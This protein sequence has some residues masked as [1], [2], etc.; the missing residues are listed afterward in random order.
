MIRHTAA[1]PCPVCGGFEAMPRGQGKRCAGFTS[2]DRAWV[3]CER[4]EHAGSL[5]LDERTTPATYLHRIGG[6]CNCGEEHAPAQPAQNGRRHPAPSERR[7]I[8]A[9]YLYTD[10][11]GCRVPYR[12]ARFEP[13]GFLPQHVTEA[14]AWANGFASEERVPY[15]LS[16]LIAEPDRVVFWCEGER[17][18]ETL[19]AAGLLATT[20]AGG[21]KS[22]RKHA[23][24]YAEHFRGRRLVAVLPDNDDDGRVYAAEV[25][26][27]LVAVGTE[28][29]LVELPGLPAKGDVSDWLDAC[30]TVEELRELVKYASRWAP[31][32]AA[33]PSEPHAIIRSSLCV[34]EIANSHRAVLLPAETGVARNGAAL[35]SDVESFLARFVVYPSE[36][37]RVAHV[38]WI[39]H[40]HNMEVWES[41]PRI[42]FLSPEPGSGKT[43]ALEVT[44]LLVPRPVLAVNCTSAFLFRRVADP[45]GLPTILFDEID[46]VFG[47][48]AKSENED[49]RGLLN[50]GHRKGAVAGRCVVKGKRIETEELP[51]YA[52]VALAGLDDLPATLESR[53]VV[54]RMRRR[55]PDELVQPF[56]RRECESQAS[57]IREALAA[58]AQTIPAGE[59][60]D[61]PAG[62]AD[63]N[64][65]VWEALLAVADAAGGTWP[66]RA[67]VTA[68]THVTD[69]MGGT[70]SLGVRLLADLRT[71]FGDSEHMLTVSIL[72]A[73]NGLDE[74]PWGDLRGRPLDARGL[75]R[76]LAKYGVERRLVRLGNVVGRGYSR[77]DLSDPWRRYLDPNVTH[78]EANP[79][80]R[81]KGEEGRSGLSVLGLGT[82]PQGPVTSVTSVTPSDDPAIIR[83]R[84]LAALNAYTP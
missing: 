74:A 32:A 22:Y 64:A 66:E 18:C 30:H 71:I 20:T 39:A 42:A 2:D 23:A 60:P 15:H 62:I 11:S 27:S 52:P 41:T 6:P 48:R 25:A 53:T 80:R 70:P 19:S 29:R 9:T 36:H 81:V 58:F 33:D 56:R 51:A 3:H 69:A 78:V 37:A 73:L 77:A 35:L 63:R 24:E 12:V 44:E 54:I 75:S 31:P 10:A 79:M 1:H 8:V 49:I 26:A 76:R 16:T 14:G 17:D 55:A 45:D 46:T 5:P 50:A 57:T 7:R 43:R 72:E 65:D 4:V 67:R 34:N 61:M 13:K 38:L 21:A 83:L 59:W 40:A 82:P 28:V 68:V 84:E 47:P